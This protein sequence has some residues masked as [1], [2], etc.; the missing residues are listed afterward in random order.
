RFELQQPQD[1]VSVT[2]GDTLT[3]TCTVSKGGPNGPVRWLKGWGD[4]N[5][6]IY[7][8]TFSIPR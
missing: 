2:V 1:K 8:Q 3:L 4:G 6:T 5:E 7:D